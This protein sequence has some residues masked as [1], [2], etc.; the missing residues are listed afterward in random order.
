MQIDPAAL[1]GPETASG[2]V[3]AGKT[4]G[5]VSA[6]VFQKTTK[7][8]ISVPRLDLE[9]FYSDLKAAIREN[10]AQY[11]EA[12]ALFL[13]GHLNQREFSSRVDPFLSF[14]PKV[15]HLH[16][17]FICAIIG[18]LSRDLPDHGVASWVSA[19][20]KL[21]VVSKPISGDGAEQRLKT[22]VM[23]LHSKDRRRLKLIPEFDPLHIPNPLEEDY[24]ARQIR[25][26][27][28]V[29][30]SAGGLNKTNWELEIRKR[31]S[32]P[33]ASETG[34]FPDVESIH[35]RMIP[36]CYEESV[37]NGAGFPCA[38]FMA[39]ATENFIKG[40]LSSVFARTRTNGPSGTING[41]M[42]RKYRRQLER[43]EM[44]FTRGELVKNTTNGLLPVEAREASGRRALGVRDIRLTLELDGGLLG[45]MP[46]VVNQVMGHYLDEELELERYE[47]SCPKDNSGMG[48]LTSPVKDAAD[49]DESS[50]GWEGGTCADREQLCFI[51][52]ECLS[53]AM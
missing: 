32:Q 42:T 18:N 45:H 15:E 50:S 35:A 33:L 51:L 36:I 44:A 13:L 37:V 53:M 41:T 10:W 31:Y 25:V 46:L 34:E 21:T 12:V 48:H 49:E 2:S 8:L 47:C 20:D 4:S 29:P 52:D 23:Q 5:T 3:A 1:A 30:P 38:A 9:P 11:K 39:L 14:D 6:P 43:E 19:N 27:D 24:Q 28:Q 7:A 16:N 40:F 22:E 17:N 26:P